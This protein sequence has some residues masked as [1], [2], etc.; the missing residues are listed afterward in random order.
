MKQTIIAKRYARAIFS[1]GQEQG[2]IES[3]AETLSSIADLFDDPELEVAETLIHPLYPP[4]A[5]YK[6]MTAIAEAVGADALAYRFA[7]IV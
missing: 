1:L 4:E 2:L 3:Y 7:I 6:V 5:R